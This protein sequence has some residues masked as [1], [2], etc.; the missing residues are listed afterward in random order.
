MVRLRPS[1][2]CLHGHGVTDLAVTNLDGLD[3]RESIRICTAYEIDGVDHTFPP[4]HRGA[5]ERALPV[6]ETLP[7]WNSDTSTCRRW[8]ELPSEAQSYLTRLSELAGAPVT[9]SYTH[10]TLPTI[11]SV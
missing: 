10:L 1:A 5:W 4:A 6:Y 8:D 7:G 3:E 9:V 2:V 11:Y